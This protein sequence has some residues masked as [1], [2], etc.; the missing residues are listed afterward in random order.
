MV[1]G[2]PEASLLTLPRLPWQDEQLLVYGMR[3]PPDVHVLGGGKSGSLPGVLVHTRCFVSLAPG[4]SALGEELVVSS[5]L[6]RACRPPLQCDICGADV[7]PE[8]MRSGGGL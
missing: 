5:F 8:W 7:W 4:R 1:S 2:V 3:T 6:L